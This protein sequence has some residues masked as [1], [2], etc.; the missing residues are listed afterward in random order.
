[1]TYSC[2]GESIPL[3]SFF[4]SKTNNPIELKGF[5]LHYHYTSGAYQ[6]PL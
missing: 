3:T 6:L 5:P 4:L 2:E 1:M